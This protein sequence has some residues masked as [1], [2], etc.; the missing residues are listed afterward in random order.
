MQRFSG[1]G[2]GSGGVRFANKSSKV[3]SLIVGADMGLVSPVS[4]LVNA[5]HVRAGG[6]QSAGVPAVLHLRGGA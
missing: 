2:D 3:V 1:G 5:L 6:S 4:P